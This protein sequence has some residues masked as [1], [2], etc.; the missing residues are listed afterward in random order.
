MV[1]LDL[2]EFGLFEIINLSVTPTRS[3]QVRPE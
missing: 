3:A 2:A 1:W